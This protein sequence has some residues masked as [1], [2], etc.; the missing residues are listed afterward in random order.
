VTVEES[1][2]AL[3]EAVRAFAI[4]RDSERFH[5]PRNLVLAL[6]GE[7]GELAAE[8]QWVSDAQVDEHFASPEKRNDFEE[9]LA[10]VLIYALRLAD[11]TGTDLGAAIRRK[12]AK[13]ATR[14]PIDL[15]RGTSL[16]HHQLPN[17][18]GD[19]AGK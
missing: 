3:T 16:K 17:E 18:G 2:S 10:D 1:W 15:S 19:E 9:E 5:T 13:N 8:L 4:E 12:L 11:V 14:Y 6:L 7:A